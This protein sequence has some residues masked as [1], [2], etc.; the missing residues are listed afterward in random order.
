MSTALAAIESARLHDLENTIAQGLKTFVEVGSALARI[1][2]ERL[3]REGYATFE[4]YCR[5]KWQM[6]R[7]NA[8]ELMQ[9]AAVVGNLSGIPDIPDTP[10]NVAQ[11]RPLASL[12][13]EKQREVW[14]EAVETAPDGKVTA[15]H[16]AETVKRM[17]SDVEPVSEIEERQVLKTFAA[18]PQ[19]EVAGL[20]REEARSA[21]SVVMD[22]ITAPTERPLT[23]E[24]VKAFYGDFGFDPIMLGRIERIHR[25][26]DL[27]VKLNPRKRERLHVI[28]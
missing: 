17:T 3:Y 20:M 5:D 28:A 27:L 15:G 10:K 12:E 19:Q 7:P 21:F 9:A 18:T 22:F 26:F 23:D 25:N 11:V 24:Q 6:S 14:T 1:R 16:V 8:Y 4:D 2:E 13:P